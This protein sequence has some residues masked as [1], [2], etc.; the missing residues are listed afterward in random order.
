M[1]ICL[2][3][4]TLSTVSD[5]YDDK[6]R[7][8]TEYIAT[9]EIG[10]KLPYLPYLEGGDEHFLGLLSYDKNEALHKMRQVRDTGAKFLRAAVT[11]RSGT[12]APKTK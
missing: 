2:I 11:D 9:L 12:S 4:A 8:N 7:K 1:W 10:T 3:L 6:K 5:L